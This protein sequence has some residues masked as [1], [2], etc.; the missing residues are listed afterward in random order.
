MNLKIRPVFISL[1]R[2]LISQPIIYSI[3]K[4]DFLRFSKNVVCLLIFLFGIN[5]ISFART[6]TFKSIQI[7]K[8]GYKIQTRI[9]GT[10]AQEEERI[11]I[12]YGELESISE[13]KYYYTVGTKT[14]KSKEK[15]IFTSDIET[16]S[17][18]S[19]YK[20]KSFIIPANAEYE[21]SY[22]IV[23]DIVF[24]L[25]SLQFPHEKDDYVKFRIEIPTGYLLDYDKD[26]TDEYS[27]DFIF[28]Q[29][30][31]TYE[32][33]FTNDLP[34]DQYPLPLRIL[35][36]PMEI[37]SL[38]MKFD[39]FADWYKSELEKVNQLEEMSFASMNEVIDQKERSEIIKESLKYVQNQIDY[40]AIENGLG[41]FIPR[42]PNQILFDKKG[43]CKDMSFLLSEY[44]NHRGIE[45]YIAISS[46]LSHPFDF[47]F[48]SLSSGNH[49]VCVVPNE[50]DYL[51]LDATDEYS[52]IDIPSKHTQ[53]RNIFIL[54]N[55]PEI[56]K[57]PVISPETNS[58]HFKML[59]DVQER[60]C[61]FEGLFKGM[62]SR[63]L[64]SSI[65]RYSSKMGSLISE[66]VL[67]DYLDEDLLEIDI[68]DKTKNIFVSGKFNLQDSDFLTVK[69]K[70]YLNIHAPFP[71]PHIKNYKN[72]LP[73]PIFQTFNTILEME[74]KFQESIEVLNLSD[75]NF[76]FSE[77]QIS[78]NSELVQDSSKSLKLQYNFVVPIVEIS[79]DNINIINKLNSTVN[80]FL[81]KYIQYN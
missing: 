38:D 37:K 46:T 60:S 80:E 68:S 78:F 43:D 57:V 51:I 22:T 10:T 64:K 30:V 33:E 58:I 17:F 55:E 59:I 70:S 6:E 47:D 1:I 21:I 81:S 18:F 66:F 53:G 72:T 24:Y 48:P 75:F 73:K 50:N 74:I 77:E 36:H 40:I 76:S 28:L 25:S 12:V 4:S 41:A 61:S 5:Q 29:D 52:S 42:D 27:N 39:Y 16:G 79:E 44:L 11:D 63:S 8:E 23:S 9:L 35:A 13:L 71:W 49:V 26:W 65:D 20:R 56:Y 69:N 3:H 2:N 14:K 19:G 62:S 31:Q 7:T 15:D 45:S 32:L 34:E 54:K 67:K